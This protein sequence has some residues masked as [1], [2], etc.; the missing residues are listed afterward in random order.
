MIY[1]FDF[2]LL[3]VRA[4]RSSPGL[5]ILGDDGLVYRSNWN[6]SAW[7]VASTISVP[8]QGLTR[9]EHDNQYVAVDT[10]GMLCYLNPYKFFLGQLFHI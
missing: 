1:L 2:E 9:S 7:D 3:C 4:Y 5:L 10:D 6:L 8:L